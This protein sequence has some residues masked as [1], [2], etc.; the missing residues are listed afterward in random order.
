[1]GKNQAYFTKEGV[2]GDSLIYNAVLL[3]Y[4]L[5]KVIKLVSY[6]ANTG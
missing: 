3:S 2:N 4:I 5:Q 6:P 1:L